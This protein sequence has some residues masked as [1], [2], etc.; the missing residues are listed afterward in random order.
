[1][2]TMGEVFVKIMAQNDENYWKMK[3]VL[4]YLLMQS[5]PSPL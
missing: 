5:I 3:E 4:Q 2:N 1:M